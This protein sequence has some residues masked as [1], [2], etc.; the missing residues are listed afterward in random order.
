QA[1][2][3]TNSPFPAGAGTGHPPESPLPRPVPVAATGPHAA[4]TDPAP[5]ADASADTGNPKASAAANAGA[6]ADAAALDAGSAG[7]AVDEVLA[8]LVRQQAPRHREG[9]AK[10]APAANAAAKAPEATGDPSKTVA[11]AE[12][13]LALQR[14]AD[15]RADAAD[16]PDSRSKADT[17]AVIRPAQAPGQS[18]MLE[19][20]RA[21]GTPVVTVETG[22]RAAA[23]QTPVQP[24]SASSTAFP[25]Q[26]V[27]V[28]I[29]RQARAG[30][31]RFQIRLD[32]PELGRIDVRLDLHRDGQ[33]QTRLT[34]DNADT[35]DAIQRDPRGLERALQNAGLK[36]D[37]G[38]VQVSLRDSGQFAQRD[39]TGRD[40]QN[41]ARTPYAS[42][43]DVADGEEMIVEAW[44][45]RA[46][47]HGRLDLSV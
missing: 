34:V 17:V 5:E 18:M 46:A 47:G 38:S 30:N 3:Q 35:F 11:A 31:H 10:P 22:V 25:V 2:S 29:A 40:P 16:K 21:D 9:D 8:Q 6:K 42:A 32:P 23:A 39:Q 20:Q 33:V 14:I 15:G 43:V 1:G 28:E 24:A 13:D 4:A 37:D 26:P 45:I 12:T 41:F 36:L 7:D 27:A 19:L 44:Q